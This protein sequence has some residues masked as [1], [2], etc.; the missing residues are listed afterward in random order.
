MKEAILGFLLAIA[1]L[2]PAGAEDYLV[3]I[4]PL[5][6]EGGY[7]KVET[8]EAVIGAAP[9]VVWRNSSLNPDCSSTGDASL[10]IVHP[11]EHG[12]A[13]ISTEPFYPNYAKGNVRYACNT[14]KTPGNRAIY[15]ASVG[16]VGRDHLVLEGSTGSGTVRRISVTI[17]VR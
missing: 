6:A 1:A 16:Y 5:R 11:P 12:T 17:D 15:T 10:R 7:K 14:Q 8:S 2:S 4:Q 13:V 3:H 9:L